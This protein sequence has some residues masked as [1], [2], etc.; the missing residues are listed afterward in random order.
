MTVSYYRVRTSP[1]QKDRFQECMSNNIIGIGWKTIG[2][3]KDNDE[4]QIREKLSKHVELIGNNRNIGKTTGFFKKMLAMKP[5]DII[6]VPHKRDI[7]FLEVTDSYEYISSLETLDLAHTVKVS[8]IK[9]LSIDIVSAKLKN[10]IN[11]PATIISLDKYHDEI[12]QVLQ[13][14]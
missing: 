11:T 13:D 9:K 7:I 6:I 10:A 1:N 2:D 5:K 3:I 4:E 8:K 14:R 12:Q